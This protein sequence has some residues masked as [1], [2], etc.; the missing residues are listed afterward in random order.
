VGASARLFAAACLFACA[1]PR[2]KAG[3]LLPRFFL[4]KGEPASVSEKE[5]IAPVGG[6]RFARPGKDG[7]KPA[8]KKE[9]SLVLRDTPC[10]CRR[11]DTR[12]DVFTVDETEGNERTHVLSNARRKAFDTFCLGD[13]SGDGGWLGSRRLSGVWGNELFSPVCVLLF[14]FSNSCF[15]FCQKGSLSGRVCQASSLHGGGVWW[16]FFGG[17]L[18]WQKGL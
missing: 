4:K 17:G 13:P 6:A 5:R 14:F 3:A 2:D 10:G 9:E 16:V 15:F 1:H 11:A 18:R 7:S 12:A 8:S